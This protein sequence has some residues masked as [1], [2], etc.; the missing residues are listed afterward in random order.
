MDQRPATAHPVPAEVAAGSPRVKG[1]S[2]LQKDRPITD[3]QRRTPDSIEEAAASLF[4][5]VRALINDSSPVDCATPTS[6][7]SAQRLGC[8]TS[9]Y[10]ADTSSSE[11]NDKPAVANKSGGDA[12]NFYHLSSSSAATSSGEQI[13]IQTVPKHSVTSSIVKNDSPMPAHYLHSSTPTNIHKRTAGDRSPKLILGSFP[14][15]DTV[16]RARKQVSSR[17]SQSSASSVE[18][19]GEVTE[20]GIDPEKV[21]EQVLLRRPFEPIPIVDPIF[22]VI[23]DSSS[24]SRNSQPRTPDLFAKPLVLH[25]KPQRAPVTPANTVATPEPL[26]SVI[27]ATP[28]VISSPDSTSARSNRVKTNRG[29]DIDNGKEHND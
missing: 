4:T 25:K 29:A 12:S 6:D 9:S 21:R 24:S 27:P 20:G 14:V 2:R 5:R 18:G 3:N 16:S 22:S 19:D 28:V 11:N 15:P 13:R 8:S 10:D 1:I 17:H 23:Y 7:I 26:I